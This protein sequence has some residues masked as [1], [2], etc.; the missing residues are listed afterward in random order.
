M[1][2]TWNDWREIWSMGP[3]Y[4]FWYSWAYRPLMIWLHDHGWHHMKICYVEGDIMDWCHWCGIRAIRP[5][6]ELIK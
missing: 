4:W 5:K 6:S 3:R 2:R 1:K